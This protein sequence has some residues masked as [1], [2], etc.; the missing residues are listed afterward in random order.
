M[1]DA[2][3]FAWMPIDEWEMWFRRAARLVL[4]APMPEDYAIFFQTDRK[5]GGEWIS[6]SS[7]ICQEADLLGI[8]LRWHRIV[9]RRE[10]GGVD[11]FRPTYSHLLCFSQKGGPGQARGDVIPSSRALYTRGTPINAALHAAQFLCSVGRPSLADPFCGMGTMLA[12]ANHY[13][14]AALGFETLP[15]LAQEAREM[16]LEKGWA[17]P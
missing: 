7:L 11:L 1:P 16:T 4:L 10:V 13:G 14:L 9:L 15:L 6:K 17:Q 12:A 3:E 8:P 5:V 2:D